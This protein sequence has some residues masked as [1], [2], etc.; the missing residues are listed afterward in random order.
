MKK[1]HNII[2]VEVTVKHSTEKAWLVESHNTGKTAWVAMSV[3][4]LD[5]NTL[6]LPEWMAEEKELV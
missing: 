3:G 1:N 5:G 6:Q 2:E 4:E